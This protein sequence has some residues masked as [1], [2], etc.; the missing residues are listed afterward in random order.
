MLK[1]LIINKSEETEQKISTE[2][3]MKS[4]SEIGYEFMEVLAKDNLNFEAMFYYATG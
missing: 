3:G 4:A 1:V 2:E